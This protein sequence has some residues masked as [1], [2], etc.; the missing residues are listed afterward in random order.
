ME[1]HLG[2]KHHKRLPEIAVSNGQMVQTASLMGADRL[3]VA[4]PA[5]TQ[6]IPALSTN[7][8]AILGWIMGE[9]A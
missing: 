8:A 4:A 7:D 5:L 6:G 3:R 9:A 2:R 1:T